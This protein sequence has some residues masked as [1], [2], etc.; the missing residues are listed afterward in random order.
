[1]DV[2]HRR[3]AG[4]EV[5]PANVVACARVQ[6]ESHV[7]REVESSATTTRDWLRL[8]DGLAERGVT[9]VVMESSGIC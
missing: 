1:M 2:I 7:I 8:A 3:C 4:L 9:H 6:S 5:P